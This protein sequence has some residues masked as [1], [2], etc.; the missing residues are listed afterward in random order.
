MLGVLTAP[1]VAATG[2]IGAWYRP[3]A[4]CLYDGVA[5]TSD[6][7]TVK[8]PTI[9]AYNARPGLEDYQ[10]VTWRAVLFR[11]T[12]SEWTPTVWS[13][14]APPY[15]TFDGEGPTRRIGVG[16]TE[17]RFDIIRGA[18]YK[19]AVRVHAYQSGTVPGIGTDY[20]W[21]GVHRQWSY[22]FGGLVDLNYCKFFGPPA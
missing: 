10:A 16:Y 8:P 20:Q 7:I 1:A 4:V 17:M 18:Y 11:W 9:L 6:S 15:W 5:G 22:T 21:A 3:A 14:W 2:Y 12:G 19:V 13:P